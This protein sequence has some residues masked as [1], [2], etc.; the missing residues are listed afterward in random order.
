MQRFKIWLYVILL[1][2]FNISIGTAQTERLSGT[3]QVPN[4]VNFNG[5]LRIK[6]SGAN[7]KNI[8]TTPFVSVPTMFQTYPIVNGTPQGIDTANFLSTDCLSPRI[9]YYIE[10]ADS[11]NI[12][13]S[14]DNWYIPRT[15]T[16]SAEIG[17]MQEQH[18]GGPITVAIPYGIIANPSVT[19]TIQQAPATNF[20]INTS[21]GGKAFYNGVELNTLI[22]PDPFSIG[23]LYVGGATSANGPDV[24]EVNGVINSTAGYKVNNSGGSP[25]QCLVSN[26]S[27]FIPGTCSAPFPSLFYQTMQQNSVSLPQRGALDHSGAFNVTDESAGQTL[28]DLRNVGTPGV[29]N[30]VA[31]LTTNQYGQ[32]TNVT[33]GGTVTFTR[34]CNSNGCWIQY[35]DGTLEEWGVSTGVPT[36]SDANTVVVVFPTPFTTTTNL[37]YVAWADNCSQLPCGSGNKNPLTVTGNGTLTT[38]NVQLVFTGVVPTG[39]GGTSLNASIH[40]HWHAWGY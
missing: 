32:I 35:P 7:L 3:V 10:I 28:I 23:H 5:Y 2:L 37:S 33:T 20:N 16:G 21:S 31:S 38:S 40:A 4:V 36:G 13:Q 22:I 1:C 39:G 30:N 34:Q 12:I 24:V 15:I 6:L 11:N 19:Q 27:T 14:T 9:P 17:A 29:Y 25:G 26:G 8:C 18:F